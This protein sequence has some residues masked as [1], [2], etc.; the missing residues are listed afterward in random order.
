VRW[1][2]ER[3][4]WLATIRINYRDKPLGAFKNKIDA[5]NARLLAEKEL[6]PIEIYQR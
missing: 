2:K 6:V 1:C 3:S 4:K 5:V